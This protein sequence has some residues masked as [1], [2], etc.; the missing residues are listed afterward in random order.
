M[1]ARGQVFEPSEKSLIPPFTLAYKKRVY[2]PNRILYP[3]KRVDWDPNGE[4]N[5]QNRG[6]SKYVRISWDEALDVIASEIRRVKDTYGPYAIMSQSRRP[7]RDQD[8]PRRPRLQQIS[9]STCWAASRCS[10][11]SRQLG[12]LVWGAKH[13]WGMEP[14]GQHGASDNLMPDIAQNSEMLLF[15]GCDPETTPWGLEGQMA[16]RLCYWWSELGIESDLHLP[17]PQLR[18]GRTCRQVDPHQAQ[19]RRRAAAGHRLLWIT[20]GTY[21][22]EYVETHTVGFDKFR[23]YVLGEEDGIAKTPEWAAEKCGVPA[24]II[25]PWPGNGR[26]NG[27]PSLTA[28]AGPCIRGPYATEPARLEVMLLGMQGLGKPGANQVKM[29][30]WGRLSDQASIPMPRASMHPPTSALRP[31]G[32]RNGTTLSIGVPSRS[33]PRTWSTTPS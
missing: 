31:T 17:R 30:E 20:E 5:T 28:T 22:K 12:R 9:C 23:D 21:D 14:V 29:I 13:V 19:H 3:L 33:S 15:W 2:S 25:R 10:P 24:R 11:Q 1:E 16:S 26:P 27:R 32:G 7:R 4:R 18:R 8:R 6:T